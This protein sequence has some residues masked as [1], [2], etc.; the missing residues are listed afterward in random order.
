MQMLINA[1]LM[2]ENKIQINGGI[3]INVN[4]SVKNVMYV[5]KIMFGIFLRVI[6]KMENDEE[7]RKKPANHKYLYFTCISIN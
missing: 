2:E 3:T 7:T 4:V 6:V 5:E 1:N